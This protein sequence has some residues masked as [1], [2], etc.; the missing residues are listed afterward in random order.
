MR[1]LL[2]S[3]ALAALFGPASALACDLPTDRPGVIDTEPRGNFDTGAFAN[4]VATALGQRFMGYA[5][6]LR[7][8]DGTIVAQINH[9]YARTPCETGGEKRFNGLTVSPI[10]SVSKALTAAVVIHRAEALDGVSLDDPF[11]NYLPERWRNELHP[12][13]QP[14]TLR[15]LLEHRGGFAKSGK[16]LWG[17]EFTMRE[18]YALGE[19][20]YLVRARNIAKGENACVPSPAAKRCYANTSFALWNLSAASIRPERWA[21]I[22]AGYSPGEIDYESYLTV[23]AY[24]L[25][26]DAAQR[27]LF[28]PVGVAGGCNVHTGATHRA[29]TYAGPGSETGKDR[30]EPGRPCAI[31]G[32]FM[33][34]RALSRAIHRVVT[35]REVI[36]A[37]HDLMFSGGDDRL[38]FASRVRVSNGYA[39]AHNGS[40]WGGQA[41]AEVVV[42]PNGYVA[43]AIANSE[44][45][46]AGPSLRDALTASYDAAL[47][48]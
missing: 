12:S 3:A 26:R 15:N 33:S 18:R 4:G 44:S 48:Q 14:V 39:F 37:N 30:A 45:G 17:H 20:S 11:R 2:I 5:V 35:T 47:P 31:G 9:G 7:D 22:E 41:K 34:T 24:N 10:G 32:W 36:D 38:V 23:Y 6:T 46:N 8:R 29:F 27:I 19:E 16:T 40:R 21:E 13:L 25:Y 43:A 28:D 42:F 1:R